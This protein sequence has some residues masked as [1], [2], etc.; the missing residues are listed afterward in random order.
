MAQKTVQTTPQNVLQMPKIGK[1]NA[2]IGLKELLQ[3]FGDDAAINDAKN[4]MQREIDAA[5]DRINAQYGVELSGEE[6]YRILKAE[7]EMAQCE[8][9]A[10]LPC[11]KRKNPYLRPHIKGYNADLDYV[12]I[13]NEFCKYEHERR[14][15]LKI[16]K[17]AG[18]SRIPAEYQGKTFADY[19][20]DADNAYAVEIAWG[21]IDRPKNGAYFFGN[22]GTGKTLLT[23]IMAQ[24]IVRRGR[25]VIFATVPNISKQIRS[26]FGGN[27]KNTEVEILE[28]LETVPTLILDDIG[29][30]KPTRF[31]CSTLC[32]LFNE[33][34]NARLQ[35]IMTS[36]YTL[37]QL[38]YIFNHPADSK[39]ET[40]DGSRIY[41]RCKQMCT[42]VEL[43]GGSRR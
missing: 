6:I 11:R 14:L 4:R 43:A 32:N 7:K 28:Q 9:C 35:T 42:P 29:I 23:A 5:R 37:K 16:E 21:L 3:T 20:V 25:Q 19:E 27:S 38:E 10:G 22:V 36:N 39:E 2:P 15:K 8:G 24:E 33:R 41:D 13:C 40:F 18:L 1:P 17:M 34:Y 12:V 31:V 30:E 26:T